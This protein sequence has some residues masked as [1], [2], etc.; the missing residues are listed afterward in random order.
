[1]PS[2]GC[3]T[4]RRRFMY[5]NTHARPLEVMARGGGAHRIIIIRRLFGLFRTSFGIFV[6]LGFGLDRSRRWVWINE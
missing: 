6:G 3:R 4:K 5:R 1:M 2:R